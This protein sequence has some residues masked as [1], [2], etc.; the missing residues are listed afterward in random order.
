M[1]LFEQIA[2]FAGFAKGEGFSFA[3]ATEGLVF[4]GTAAEAV[5]DIT[6]LS[7]EFSGGAG[8]AGPG[9]YVT[10]KAAE[11]GQY[12]G[13]ATIATGGRVVAGKIRAGVSLLDANAPL[14][15]EL[16]TKLSGLIGKTPQN[17]LEAI[18]A[19]RAADIEL[20]EVQKIVH[21]H[22]GV[23]GV[24]YRVTYGSGSTREALAF[25]GR[26]I[27]GQGAEQIFESA[28]PTLRKLAD[29]TAADMLRAGA[30]HDNS[31]MLNRS[32]KGI[33]G[34]RKTSAAL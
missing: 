24:Q 34:S 14:S 25:F 26:G 15:G 30:G 32:M 21:A 5:T 1:P 11:A 22:T 6:K 29:Q 17:Y 9:I 19:A 4:H 12:A 27:T 16:Q 7:E 2:K 20:E 3:K 10:E 23:A 33:R 28:L 13:P 8:V 18:Q 31:S